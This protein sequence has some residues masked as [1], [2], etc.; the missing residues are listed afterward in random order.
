[1]HISQNME[2]CGGSLIWRRTNLA[3]HLGVFAA[4]AFT[5]GGGGGAMILCKQEGTLWNCVISFL[6]GP[7][8]ETTS[9]ISSNSGVFTYMLDLVCKY[10][11]NIFF[12]HNYACI[13]LMEYAVVKWWLLILILE[14]VLQLRRSI[15]T[16]METEL[17]S[18]LNN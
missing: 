9:R 8:I 14:R 16:L 5:G 12:S 1:M 11:W 6:A 18:L 13:S 17:V 7:M 2:E 4:L 15:L 10:F 3:G